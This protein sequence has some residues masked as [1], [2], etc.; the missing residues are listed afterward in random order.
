MQR[1]S[2]WPET[3]PVGG[4]DTAV[5]LDDLSFPLSLGRLCG[6][7]THL[8]GFPLPFLASTGHSGG[9]IAS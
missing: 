3:Q 2:L 4:W 9:E 5:N 7:E 8:L 6:W 1:G